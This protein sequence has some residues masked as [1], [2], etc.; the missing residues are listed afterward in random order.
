VFNVFNSHAVTQ[1][2]AENETDALPNGVGGGPYTGFIKDSLYLTPLYYQ[3]PRS[4]RL[5]L[6]LSWGGHSEPP[7]PPVAAPVAAPVEAAPPPP[8]PPPAPVEAP[9]PP[10]PAPAPTGERG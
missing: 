9:P 1:R 3:T 5:G 2:Y 7:P 4:V 10:P 6:D 8:P